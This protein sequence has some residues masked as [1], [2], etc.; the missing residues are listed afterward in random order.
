MHSVTGT[1]TWYC[2]PGRSRCTRGYPGGLYAAISR[3]LLFLRG[4]R[5]RVC[6]GSSCVVVKVIDCNCGKGVTKSIDLYA[7]AFRAIAPLT[8]GRIK[9]TIRY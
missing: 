2:L 7:D 8:A 9:V 1:A 4:K 3:D 5:V 6:H